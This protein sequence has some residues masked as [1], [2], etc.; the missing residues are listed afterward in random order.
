M[1]AWDKGYETH[2]KSRPGSIPKDCYTL[3][4]VQKPNAWPMAE[5]MKPVLVPLENA[6]GGTPRSSTTNSVA[7]A[8]PSLVAPLLLAAIQPYITLLLQ[9]S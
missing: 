1:P 3:E 5:E 9:F 8:N 7:L 6:N 2:T 4:S